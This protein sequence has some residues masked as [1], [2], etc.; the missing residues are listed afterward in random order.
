MCPK[1]HSF[2]DRKQHTENQHWMYLLLYFVYECIQND[3]AFRLTHTNKVTHTGIHI[4]RMV[5][6]IFRLS[7]VRY[8]ETKHIFTSTYTENKW[9]QA[10]MHSRL[11][12]RPFFFLC[13]VLFNFSFCFVRSN[14]DLWCHSLLDDWTCR[15][16]LEIMRVNKKKEQKRWTRK[17]S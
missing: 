8:N 4:F 9:M 15:Y 7:F 17:F 3:V 14:I 5:L 13:V 1:I 16:K 11:F 6:M 10:S 12:G 2:H